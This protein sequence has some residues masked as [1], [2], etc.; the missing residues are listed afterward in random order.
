[1]VPPGDLLPPPGWPPRPPLGDITAD[2]LGAPTWS[3]G[4]LVG[5]FRGHFWKSYKDEFGRGGRKPQNSF[6]VVCPQSRP[7][8]S[9]S[10][11]AQ[12]LPWGFLCV[13]PSYPPGCSEG[14]AGGTPVHLAYP[15][16]SPIHPSPSPAYTISNHDGTISPSHPSQPPTFK[17]LPRHNITSAFHPYTSRIPSPRSAS[18]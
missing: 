6:Q 18:R 15:S 11:R 7:P 12:G 14:G 9:P 3:R 5:L 16:I 17:T 13:S 10:D 1:M 4:L 8:S 2:P